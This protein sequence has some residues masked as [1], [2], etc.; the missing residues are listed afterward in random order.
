MAER[1]PPGWSVTVS[2][3]S[4][5]LQRLTSWGLIAS[6]DVATGAPLLTACIHVPSSAPSSSHD[7]SQE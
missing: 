7:L 4:K 1:M 5:N 2:L 6:A 3:T